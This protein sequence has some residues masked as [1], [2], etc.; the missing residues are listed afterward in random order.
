MYVCM[1]ALLIILKSPHKSMSELVNICLPGAGLMD[2]LVMYSGQFTD[3]NVL[4]LFNSY[5]LNNDN[6]PV[7]TYMHV[8]CMYLRAYA[9]V[10]VEV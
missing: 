1:Y 2:E 4:S 5:G 9:C 6:G 10:S 7:R 3:A 8:L